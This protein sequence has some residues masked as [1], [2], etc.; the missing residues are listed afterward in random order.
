MLFKQL[1]GDACVEDLVDRV[2]DRQTCCPNAKHRAAG[3]SSTF[4]ARIWTR[5][6]C[7]VEGVQAIETVEVRARVVADVDP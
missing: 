6:A 7:D 5:K 3:G 1:V 2:T 4:D